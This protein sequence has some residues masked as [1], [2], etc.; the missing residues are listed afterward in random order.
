M[1]NGDLQ[2]STPD[3]NAAAAQS[4]QGRPGAA[5]IRGTTDAP[6][7]VAPGEW[8]H[9]R[10]GA[11][12]GRAVNARPYERAGDDPIY[13]PLQ[14]YA[15]DPGISRTEGALAL[16]KTPYEVLQPGPVGALFAVDNHD[17]GCNMD[18]LRVD[19]NDPKNLIQNGRTPSPSDPQFHQQMVYV[20]CSSTYA[21]FKRALGRDLAWGF[22][23]EASAK[24][25]RLLVRPHAF[26]GENAYY[27]KQAGELCFGYYRAQDKVS[28]RNL[29][30]G[31]VFTCLS[32]DIIAHEVTHALLDGLRANFLFPSCADVLA[33]HEAFADLVAIF[34]HFSYDQVVLAA[35]RESRGNLAEATLLTGIAQQFGRTTTGADRPLRTTIDVHKD[36]QPPQYGT[37][38]MEPHALGSL[39][40]SAVFEAF[41]TIFRRKTAQY[42]RLATDGTGVLPAGDMPFEL[43]SILA[44]EASKLASQFLNICIRAIDY[45]PPTDMEFGDFLRA[46]ITADFD[47]VPD[48]PWNYREAWIDA[49]RRRGIYPRH[50]DHLSG[51]ALIWRPPQR[52]IAAIYDLCFGELRFEGDP[53]RAAG[54]EEL[55]R[56]A[57][58]LGWTVARPDLS[59]EFGCIAPGDSRLGRDVVDLPS[60]ESIRTAHRVGPDGQIVYDLV[61]EVTQ[62]RHVR[63]ARGRELFEFY[64]GATVIL[65]PRGRVRYVIRKS[66]L[67]DER[68]ERQ[69]AFVG[70]EL[71]QRFWT[72][73]EGKQVPQHL[74]FRQLHLA[75]RAAE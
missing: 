7:A 14:I 26:V 15:L 43:Q 75:E 58:A 30:H 46:V 23:Q 54:L 4:R 22:G 19:L 53:G 49:F 38:S 72:R 65:D 34:Q 3:A 73:E 36:G 61:A 52:S 74:L 21:A 1:H 68:L 44:L 6:D 41:V 60:I 51:D 66:V 47:L 29:P 2:A 37:G 24:P 71:G 56:Q 33:F 42:V 17:G 5:G 67:N 48:D 31:Y 9:Y 69:R 25:V 11:G 59:E 45:C 70:S 50:V 12:V 18:Y 20:V 55:R 16:V 40:V 28:G 8:T 32:H 10:L 39:L 63:D 13:R 62:C 35:L 64:G 57:C 27:D